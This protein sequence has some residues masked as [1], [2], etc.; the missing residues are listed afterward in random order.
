MSLG[1]SQAADDALRSPARTGTKAAVPSFLPARLYPIVDVR[2]EEPD[3]ALRL[4]GAFV[5]AGAPW[6]QLRAKGV[7]AGP[8]VRLATLVVERA[9]REGTRVI[10]NDRLDVA[11]ASGAAGVHL[12]Q[13]D[14]PLGAARGLAHRHGLV[15]GISTHDVREA[16]DAEDGGADYIGFGPIFATAT[17]HDSLHPR[18]QG[19]LAAVR[20]AVRLPIVAIGGITPETAAAVLAAGADAVAMIG[21]LARCEDPRATAAALL[22]PDGGQSS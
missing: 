12:G 11:L 20:A 9:A 17:K 1:R 18:A 13:E 14:L 16:R 6:L 19:A 4:T 15:V 10:V 5:E 8:F 7:A 3:E 21:A 22:D 2:E